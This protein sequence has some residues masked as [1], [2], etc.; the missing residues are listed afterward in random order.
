MI[1]KEMISAIRIELQDTGIESPVWQEDDLIRAINKSVGLL[2]KLIPKRDII[3][4]TITR[5][6]T[7]ETLTIA[8]SI[9]TLAYKPI[10]VG[11][12]SIAGKVLDTDYRINYLTGVVTEIGS[13]LTDGD[14]TVSYTLDPQMLDISN[15]LS[16]YIRIERVEYPAGDIPTTLPT[17]DILGDFLVLRSSTLTESNHLRMIYLRKW[18]AP[19]L[20]SSGDYPTHLES[21]IIIGSAGQ[22]LIFMAEKYTQGAIT[23]IVASKTVLDDISAI[24]MATAPT[25]T[26]E[27]SDADTALNAAITRF[28]AAVS[29]ADKGDSPLA[30]ADTAID[31]MA[32]E[33]ALGAGFLQTGKDL[34][35]VGTRGDNVGETYGA[36]AQAE[37]ALALA[38][39]KEAEQNIA[40]A[41]SWEARAA[42]ETTIGNS[43]INEA[44]Q[45]LATVARLVEKY[46][47]ELIGDATEVNYFRAQIEKATSYQTL[48]KQYLEAS[49]RYLAS[50]QAKI[51]EFLVSLGLKP[52]FPTQKASSEQFA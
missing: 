44:I 27:L 5:T 24:T 47:Q 6:I 1:L 23:N 31:K 30:S 21:P 20:V 4:T 46:Q 42:R 34:I 28:E 19:T 39:G 45:R 16:D 35:N 51:N 18:L 14:Y 33:T 15:L 36:Y 32:T 43:Y 10:K 29:E 8:D 13:L 38:Y 17:F 41:N 3:E 22:A 2:S 48:A 49:G 12:V 7:N 9:G 25:I 11:S 40:V 50:G 26:T 52:E 37:V